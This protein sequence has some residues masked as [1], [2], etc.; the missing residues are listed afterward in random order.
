MSD[1]YSITL[2]DEYHGMSRICPAGPYY[3]IRRSSQTEKPE[4]PTSQ[5]S[6]YVPSI[7]HLLDFSFAAPLD[8][9]TLKLACV[10]RRRG[11]VGTK[12]KTGRLARAHVISLAQMETM[13]GNES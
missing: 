5:T 8:L 11:A 7:H 1:L 4:S 6:T 13:E 10:E 12:F 3:L 2:R 9:E